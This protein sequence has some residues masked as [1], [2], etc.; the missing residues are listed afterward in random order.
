MSMIL[1]FT[2]VIALCCIAIVRLDTRRKQGIKD[3]V[4]RIFQRAEDR[5]WYPR[6]PAF[7]HDYL[8]DYPALRLLEEGYSDVRA[9]CLVLLEYKAKLTDV[10]QLGGSY[11]R[12]GIH[13]AR[14]KSFMFKSG[15]F[16][17]ENCRR[18][19]R[20]AALLR[21]IPGLYTAFFSIL[22]PHQEI[23]PHRGYYK[24]FVRYHLGVIVPRDNADETCW[25][26]VNADREDNH[27]GPLEAVRRGERYYW[28]EG[29]GVIFDDTYLHDAAN[30]SDEV[31]VVLWLDLRRRM[32]VW[33]Q[34]FNRLCLWIAHQEPSIAKIRRNAVVALD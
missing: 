5:G 30:E 2:A 23:K 26:R 13:S 34:A 4:N 20:T 29:K 8:K 1:V 27:T 18:A 28:R 19:P 12:G 3:S 21:E 7:S 32:P 15:R 9:E 17:E 22:D 11:T 16:I 14:W 33:L 25:L 31:R 10:E 6:L 24:G